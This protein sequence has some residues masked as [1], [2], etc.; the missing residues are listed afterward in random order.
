MPQ[1]N[2]RSGMF[3]PP[4]KQRRRDRPA[5]V[6]PLNLSRPTKHPREQQ[7]QYEPANLQ[8]STLS[9]SNQQQ[10]EQQYRQHQ[11]QRS[12]EQAQRVAPGQQGQYRAYAPEITQLSPPTYLAELSGDERPQVVQKASAA[13]K[14]NRSCQCIDG[15]LYTG[16]VASGHVGGP[17][18]YLQ[19]PYSQVVS[20]HSDHQ[21]N[22]TVTSLLN[23]P[24]QHPIASHQHLR[25]NPPPASPAQQHDQS[26]P[27]TNQ[28]PML[29]VEPPVKMRWFVTNPD[30]VAPNTAPPCPI[31]YHTGRLGH[32]ELCV[33]DG[34][35]DLLLSEESYSTTASV[36]ET[37]TDQRFLSN[38]TY[39][40]NY[41]RVQLH[42]LPSSTNDVNKEV[43]DPQ[44]LAYYHTELPVIIVTTASDPYTVSTPEA[45]PTDLVETS[46]QALRPDAKISDY[47][48]AIRAWRFE[49]EEG[50][51]NETPYPREI[52]VQYVQPRADSPNATALTGG[53]KEQ[54]VVAGSK[55]GRRS[56]LDAVISHFIAENL[57]RA[58]PTAA[59]ILEHGVGS[60]L[61]K[62]QEIDGN[63]S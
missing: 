18:W 34:Q 52:A 6:Q 39:M 42:E 2:E 45:V 31:D 51:T 21:K 58:V 23:S 3:A 17:S 33:G 13:K 36:Q 47:Y 61:A 56:S 10:P 32:H 15:V 54:E 46:D 55:S 19:Y 43:E 59:A 24:A 60:E 48:Q 26:K 5:N 38:R 12:L 22:S 20:Q 40:E 16:S 4:D 25:L 35:P 63:K 41:G 7:P 11:P 14:A 27:S 8:P 44:T 9:R 62:Q 37:E 30:P 53:G 57:E 28:P 1:E 49:H 50:V 29:D